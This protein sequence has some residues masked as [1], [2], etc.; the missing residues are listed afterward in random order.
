MLPCGERSRYQ[1]ALD[2]CNSMGN[3]DY[4]LLLV[5]TE[6]YFEQNGKLLDTPPNTLLTGCAASDNAIEESVADTAILSE[7][8]SGDESEVSEGQ[9]G[10]EL[11]AVYDT[12]AG[13]IDFGST[14]I[15]K[16]I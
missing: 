1:A 4:T 6:A 5:K 11:S 8:I 15:S 10:M 7:D 9:G 14:S 13:N 3:D 2:T 16:L 12:T